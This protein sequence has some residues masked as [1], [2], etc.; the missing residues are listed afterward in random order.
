MARETKYT[1]RV[2]FYAAP[3]DAERLRRL[4]NMLPAGTRS[5]AARVALRA[6][7]RL[8]ETDP[9]AAMRLGAEDQTSPHGLRDRAP[10]DP[11]TA[12]PAGSGAAPATLRPPGVAPSNEASA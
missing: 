6:G 10:L 2:Q 12:P 9:S 5:C 7:L 3:E 1:E 4:A 11:N 8:L